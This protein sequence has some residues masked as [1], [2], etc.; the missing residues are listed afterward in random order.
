MYLDRT[1]RPRRRRGKGRFLWPLLLLIVLGIILYEQQPTWLVP[2][3]FQPTPV[4][5]RSAV[6]YLSEAEALLAESDYDGAISAYLEMARLEPND[7]MPLV[8]LSDLYLLLQDL[9]RSLQYAQRAYELDP[10]DPVVLTKYAHISDWTGDYEGAL[11]LALDAL[12]ID[13]ASADTLAVLAE[14]Y[15]DVGNWEV[16]QDYLDQSFALEPDN[17]GTWRNQ[18]YLYERQGEYEAAIVAYD[19]AIEIAPNRFDLYIERGRQQRV[20]LL[21]YDGA[22]DSY[23]Q[24]VE[25][26]ESA[27]TLDALGFGLYNVGDH[28]QAV[29]VLRD[30]VE[31]DPNYGPALVHLGMALYARR[32]YE[33]AVPMLEKGVTLL[34]DQARIEHIYTLGLAYIYKDP[35]DC[36]ASEGWLRKALVIVPDT[37]PALEGLALCNAALPTRTVDSGN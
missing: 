5:T 17:V 25:V 23:R 16:A 8:E 12:E 28:L 33:D 15:T 32:N 11:N 26:Y 18:A 14:V 9:P 1:Y 13:P 37:G 34:G 20:G 2:Q 36:A 31:L 3:D 10:K 27:I 7:P 29:R 21:D 19:K 35:S 24:A 30:A 6:S 4:P 22:N